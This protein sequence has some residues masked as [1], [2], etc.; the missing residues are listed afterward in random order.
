MNPAHPAYTGHVLHCS[1]DATELLVNGGRGNVNDVFGRLMRKGLAGG[2]KRRGS[3]ALSRPSHG[4]AQ[5]ASVFSILES[6]S[7]ARDCENRLMELFDFECYDVI[8]KFL[9]NR[10]VVVWCAAMPKKV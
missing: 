10:E 7:S 3:K 1:Q 4:A 6:D 8:S 9:K 2:R 5:A